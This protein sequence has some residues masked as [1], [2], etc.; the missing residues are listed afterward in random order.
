MSPSEG[1]SIPDSRLL[2]LDSGAQ[3]SLLGWYD[4]N[5][6]DLPWR[7]TRDPYR[8]WVSE[9]M[10]QQT[11]VSTVLRYFDRFTE[12][13]STLENLSKAS[14]S[15][16]LKLWEGLGY[17]QR[18]RNLH[19]AAGMIPAGPDGPE[20]PRTVSEWMDLPGIGRSTAGAILS[21]ST[22]TWAPILDANVRRVMERFYSIPPDVQAREGLLWEGSNL[23]G[24]DNGR[25][26]DTNQALMELGAVV[27]L[28]SGPDCSRCPVF[29]HC[30]TRGAGIGAKEE[31]FLGK[32]R[33]GESRAKTVRERVALIPESGPLLLEPRNEGRLLEGLMDFPGFSSSALAP[34][35]VIV[36]GPFRGARV[37]ETLFAVRQTYSH[38]KEVVH[39]TLIAPSEAKRRKKVVA[40]SADENGGE[41]G[42]WVSTEESDALALTGVARKIVDRLGNGRIPG[43]A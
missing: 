8:I 2:K 20:W 23:W 24:R 14:L 31:G 33:M 40:F 17:Y 10:L 35:T 34:G 38:F 22:D 25:P 18:A 41:M 27:C 42:Q 43:R 16:V 11:T 26:G 7:K 12:R 6:R 39:V 1:A 32:K 9:I 3:G 29:L 13:F 19:R 37:V 4:L 5:R 36:S 28:P 15:E 30:R 21:I